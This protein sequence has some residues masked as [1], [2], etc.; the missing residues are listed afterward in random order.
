MKGIAVTVIAILLIVLWKLFAGYMEIR[1]LAK[2]KLLVD[3]GFAF[4]VILCLSMMALLTFSNFGLCIPLPFSLSWS[5]RLTDGIS[6]LLRLVLLS[7]VGITT[8]FSFWTF[9]IGVRDALRERS[10]S[11]KS[12]IYYW[13]LGILLALF[14]VLEYVFF[15]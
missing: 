2:R 10:L 4:F 14:A 5:N 15:C 8:F 7:V 11:C 9:G 1:R 6:G 3:I 12:A 13:K